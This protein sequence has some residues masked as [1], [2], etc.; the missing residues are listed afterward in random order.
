MRWKISIESI[1]EIGGCDDAEM[2]IKKEFVVREKPI[3]L[4]SDE[5][6]GCAKVI[7]FAGLRAVCG[8]FLA[9]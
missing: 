5:R 8:G 2:V 7:V 1:D 3:S 6:Y 9:N 4:C